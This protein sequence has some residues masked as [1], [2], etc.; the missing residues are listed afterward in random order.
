MQVQGYVISDGGMIINEEQFVEWFLARETKV[1]REINHPVPL[2]PP[3]ISHDLMQDW[4][5]GA[6][7]G[8]W[9]LM[10]WAMPQ[11]FIHDEDGNNKS[12]FITRLAT[13]FTT[14]SPFGVP[15][16]C[17]SSQCISGCSS[18]R[19]CACVLLNT[20]TKGMYLQS[21]TDN[22]NNSRGRKEQKLHW[23]YKHNISFCNRSHALQIHEKW[24]FRRVTLTKM[25]QLKGSALVKEHR[26]LDFK[27]RQGWMVVS[28]SYK[29]WCIR[30]KK[31][32]SPRSRTSHP[33]NY[34]AVAEKAKNN[35]FEF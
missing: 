30:K 32:M 8:S 1:L 14:S 34:K 22:K 35:V 11:P 31:Q 3:Q 27:A 10:T 26:I 15:T 33:G 23:Q 20:S 19:Y 18:V 21:S 17:H 4:I 2:C 25:C 29:K 9:W 13:T 6:T 5:W 24:Q 28:V 12:L 7:V 16:H